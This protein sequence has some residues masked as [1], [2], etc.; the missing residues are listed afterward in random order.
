LVRHIDV[1]NVGGVKLQ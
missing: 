1:K